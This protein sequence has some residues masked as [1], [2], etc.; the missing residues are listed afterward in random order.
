MRH[1]EPVVVHAHMPNDRAT[2]GHGTPEATWQN[3]G[4]LSTLPEVD[5]AT[6]VPPGARAV[7]VSPHPDDEILA[8]GGLLAQLSDLGRKALIIAVTDGTAS[9]PDSPEWP[10][11]RLAATRPQETRAALPRLRI[12]PRH[13]TRRTIA[14]VS[15]KAAM[16]RGCFSARSALM[17]VIACL[18]EE[19]RSIY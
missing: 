8:T 10:A 5:P 4:R 14:P 18:V 12:R 1:M 2:K 15:T 9:H 7:I 13:R 17:C 6:L 11:A 3:S 19:P 16:T